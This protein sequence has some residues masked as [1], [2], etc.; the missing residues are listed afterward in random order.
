[1]SSNKWNSDNHDS[2]SA[3]RSGRGSRRSEP[4]ASFEHFSSA[5]RYQR[6]HTKLDKATQSK[7]DRLT[8]QNDKLSRTNL[9]LSNFAR[10]AMHFLPDHLKKEY[11]RM[12]E[13]IKS[14]SFEEST[15]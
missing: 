9:A 14:G 12:I 15:L 5:N 7:L 10:R 11:D 4:D 13:A 1:M 8:E 3:G 6:D 2:R